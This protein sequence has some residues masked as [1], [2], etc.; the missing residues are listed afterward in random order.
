MKKYRIFV[1][2]MQDNTET[3]D[4]YFA[5]YAEMMSA[6]TRKLTHMTDR[7]REI[8]TFNGAEC[9]LLIPDEYVVTSAKQLMG[10]VYDETIECEGYDVLFG[11]FSNELNSW[12]ESR[13]YAVEIDDDVRR[14]YYT[15]VFET[16]TAAKDYARQEAESRFGEEDDRDINIDVY[17]G[18]ILLDGT[19]EKR[20]ADA[21]DHFDNIC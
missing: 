19:L 16:E 15:K 3:L 13:K 2:T 4:E 12:M 10:D 9:E 6:Y 7:E 14:E 21:I 17:R 8:R 1:L 20:T 11:T 5:S 18:L